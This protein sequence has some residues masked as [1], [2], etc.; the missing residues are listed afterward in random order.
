M[1]RTAPFALT[2]AGKPV[3]S[4]GLLLGRIR[5]PWAAWEILSEDVVRGWNQRTRQRDQTA[6]AAPKKLAHLAKRLKKATVSEKTMIVGKIRRMTPGAE[7][8]IDT[9]QLR[10]RPLVSCRGGHRWHVDRAGGRSSC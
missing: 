9:W 1:S 6:A 4:D 2:L 8:V 7:V 10:E 3:T 5:P